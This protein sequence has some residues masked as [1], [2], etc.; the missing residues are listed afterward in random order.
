MTGCACCTP[1]RED[2]GPALVCTLAGGPE[3]RQARLADWRSAISQ[4][5]DREPAAGGV[6]LTF[7][8]DS[9]LAGELGRLAAVEY[10]CCS[11]FT[12]TLSIGPAGMAFTAQAPDAARDL[13]TA[14][15]GDAA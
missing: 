12:F 3:A 5:T 1:E 9:R 6:T 15:F 14:L 2:D 7:E 10:E 8:H 4:A 11:F 13:V